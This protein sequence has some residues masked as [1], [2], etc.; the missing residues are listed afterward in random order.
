MAGSVNKVILVGNLGR[1]P[2]IR[3]L[4]SG[5]RVCNLSVATSERWNDRQSGEKRERTEW[6]RVVVFNENLV[7]VCERFLRKGSKVYVEGQLETRKWTDQ[8]SQQERYSTEVVL[9]QFRSELTIL[10]SRQ[11]GGQGGYD[12]GGGGD[13]DQGSAPA[14]A[15]SSG[16]A[17][18]RD[19]D[20]D[21]PF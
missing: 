20:D 16:P 1:D 6:H 18:A 11:D 9:R 19:L 2:E 17:P 10:D 12:Q 15:R 3:S 13:Y 21:I 8:Q 14:P 5:G 7:N 4:P